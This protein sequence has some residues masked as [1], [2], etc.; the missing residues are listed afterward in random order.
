M[1]YWVWR[2]LAQVR[3]RVVVSE[4][5]SGLVADRV[6]LAYDGD[7]VR[8]AE[9]P[10]ASTWLSGMVALAELLGCRFVGSER[11]G[12]NAFF[13]RVVVARPALAAVGRDDGLAVPSVRRSAALLSAEFVPFLSTLTWTVDP[14]TD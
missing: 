3:L 5:N 11:F 1:E 13:V 6:T 14:P 4:V 12:I 2:A 9:V 7:F 10:F 8:P